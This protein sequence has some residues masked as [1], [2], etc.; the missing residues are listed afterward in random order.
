MTQGVIIH[1]LE[2]GLIIKVPNKKKTLENIKER[3][4]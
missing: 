3:E 4:S 2:L 1:D